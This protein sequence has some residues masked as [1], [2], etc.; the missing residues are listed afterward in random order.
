MKTINRP[1]PKPITALLILLAL[2]ALR[3]ETIPLASI[4]LASA[5][6]WTCKG[7][8][9]SGWSAIRIPGQKSAG[10]HRWM[11]F[12]RSLSIPN[13]SAGQSTLLRFL[14]VNEGGII[15]I[16]NVPVD[17]IYY[18]IFPAETDITGYVKPG[19]THTLTVR[20]FNRSKYHNGIA[21]IANGYTYSRLGMPRGVSL[22]V[23][24]EVRIA[25][26]YLRTSVARDE[27]TRDL[28]ISNPSAAARTLTIKARMTPWNPGDAWN[29]P[30]I[31]DQVV[32]IPARTLQK[33]TQPPVAWGL[34]A[35]SYW[36]PNIPFEE[37]YTARLHWL[38]VSVYDG[39]RKLDSLA[40]RFG[41]A[42]YTE[43]PYY[44][45]I[46]GV[47][48][49][50]FGDD[51][52]ESHYSGG[53]Q[54]GFL[55][56]E[57][58][59]DGPRGA[60]ETWKRYLRIGINSYRIHISAATRAM[61]DAA[62]EVGF[63][64][65][66]N[67]AILGEKALQE[68]WHDDFKPEAVRGMVRFHRKHPSTVRYSMDNEWAPATNN[69]T[70]ARKLIDATKS[71][72]TE[73]P[74]SFSQDQP[75]WE[76]KLTGTDG[77]GHGWPMSHYREPPDD[78][79][80]IKGVEEI[81]WPV[82]SHDAGFERLD[83]A[84]AAIKFRMRH[85]AVFMPWCWKNYWSNFVEGSSG[86]SNRTDAIDGWGS[87]LVRFIRNCYHVFASADIDII[88]NRVS[89]DERD[90]FPIANAYAFE[91]APSASRNMV[92]FNNSLAPHSMRI[93]WEL[94]LDSAK[95]GMTASGTT[96]TV[97]LEPGRFTTPSILLPLPGTNSVQR[98][99]HFVVKTEVDGSI[100]FTEDQY[101]FRVKN[102]GAPVVRIRPVAGTGRAAAA[103]RLY[104]ASGRLIRERAAHAGPGF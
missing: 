75:P 24:P 99:V 28:W 18:S 60:K 9:E 40:Q 81:F 8:T 38:H 41:F 70:Y 32:T 94:R 48:V 3:A 6:A 79:V 83:C 49:F 78:T 52:Q 14:S 87:P 20:C 30:S 57:G 97:I 26:A 43:G 55:N 61:V 86:S 36:W 51:T 93:V 104:N 100:R 15:L 102:P 33:V 71:E 21:Y 80:H 23:R 65:I 35:K 39:G 13:V 22:E 2:T 96:E 98:T 62:D 5:T 90:F 64:L 27:F 50:Q 17:T 7:E 67:S 101:V 63:M 68:T 53:A 56:T 4:D 77:V 45:K 54:L 66:P 34:G 47:H 84:R 46:N 29:Y 1:C 11:D 19:G 44:Y 89:N 58:W 76:V 88:N 16:D 82:K 85:Y 31:P 72:D 74:I 42:E 59:G 69:P 37:A 73:R 103:K 95:G 25:D 92:M 12:R 10:S 91:N